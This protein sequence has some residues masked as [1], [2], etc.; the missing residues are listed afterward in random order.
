MTGKRNE[1]ART[2]GFGR[3]LIQNDYNDFAPRVGIAY[4]LG[5][6][7]V[8]RSGFG[9][10]YNSTFVQEL[11]DLRK[12]WPFTIQQVFSPNRGTYWISSITDPGP[13]FSEHISDR[14]LAAESRESV[15]V[16]D[17]VEL[18]HPARTDE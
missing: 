10:F 8:I 5:S 4:K 18:L 1:P 17:A 7:T 6:K 2:F 15:A 13:S 14:R 3:A 12:F 9:M 16:L 11:Q